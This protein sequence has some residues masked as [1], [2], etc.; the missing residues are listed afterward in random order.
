MND[1]QYKLLDIMKWIHSLCTENNIK[2]TLIG[3]SLIGAVREKG[4]IPW[5]DDI[6]IAMDMANYAKFVSLAKDIH[7]DKYE[8]LLPLKAKNYIYA[9][10]KVID[11][12]TTLIEK[13][14]SDNINLAK[15]ICIDI[16]PMVGINSKEEAR[17]L[18]KK[19]LYYFNLTLLQQRKH[20]DSTK[21]KLLKLA[22][23]IINY[24][25]FVKKML[26]HNNPATGLPYIYDVDGYYCKRNNIVPSDWF[27]DYQLIDFETEKFM[28]IT[29]Y[30]EYLT[31]VFGDYMVRPANADRVG[32]EQE[33]TDLN[34][35]YTEYIRNAKKGKKQ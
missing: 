10:I 24:R 22:K 32:H 18:T 19:R 27:K 29:K 34:T 16:F 15:G 12:N 14:L 35:P 13:K 5:D 1:L 33:F 6:D 23:P 11:K 25:L 28:A 4:F 31:E 9:F 21:Q 3:G 17:E 30:D 26:K 20:L 2:Y 8:V 7:H